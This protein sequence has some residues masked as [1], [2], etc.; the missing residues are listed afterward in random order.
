ML[1]V[2]AIA[3]RCLTQIRPNISHYRP[4]LTTLA[5]GLPVPRWP[6][7]SLLTFYIPYITHFDG[8]DQRSAVPGNS[9][10][11]HCPVS[12]L[13]GL[14]AETNISFCVV[15]NS[16]VVTQ[17]QTKIYR[18]IE[19]GGNEWLFEGKMRGEGGNPQKDILCDT[20]GH[21]SRGEEMGQGTEHG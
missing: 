17:R 15:S 10:H 21:L 20:R 7:P 18:G 13:P 3:Q 8:G 9:N 12:P 4:S 19:K 5:V 1:K 14:S 6:M 2:T 11:W 16:E